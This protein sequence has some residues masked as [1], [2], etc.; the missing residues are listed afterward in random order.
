M[1]TGVKDLKYSRGTLS[2]AG[3]ALSLTALA[4]WCHTSGCESIKNA[5]LLGIPVSVWG[6]IYF[7]AIFLLLMLDGMVLKRVIAFSRTFLLAM[8]LGCDTS[9]VSALVATKTFCPVC[10]GIAAVMLFLC[11]TE[12]IVLLRQMRCLQ[13]KRGRFVLAKLAYSAAAFCLGMFFAAFS[14]SLPMPEFGSVAYAASGE[15]IPT[16]GEGNTCIRIYSDYF[17]PGCRKQETELAALIQTVRQKN[18]KV[19]FVDVPMH[20]QAT[21]NYSAYFAACYC[22]DSSMENILKARHVLF[23]LAEQGVQDRQVLERSLRQARVRF[24]LDYGAIFA[25]FNEANRLIREDNVIATPT[26][27]VVEKGGKKTVLRGGKINR[28]TLLGAL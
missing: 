17:C 24:N 7:S 10:L 14:Y 22:A 21:Q 2:L 18:C 27:V 23:R 15:T 28:N 25:Y 4:G 26:V 9:L 13:T 3:I 16:I 11:G 20:G 6:L 12:V 8:G 5:L 19:C 1:S